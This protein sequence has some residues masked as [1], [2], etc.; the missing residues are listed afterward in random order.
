M[1]KNNFELH[2][3]PANATDLCQP[4]DS[5]IISKIKDAWTNGWNKKKLDLI[6]DDEWQEKVRSDGGWSGKL[7]NPGKSFFLRLAAD[8][9]RKVNEQRDANEI[10]YARRAMIRCGLSL[11]L[12]AK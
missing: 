1:R 4:A 8:A 5:F 6:R 2:H 10:T 7:K 12:D 3:L 11:D 9:V